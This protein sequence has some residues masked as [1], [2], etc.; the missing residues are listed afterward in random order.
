[1]PDLRR[2][3][4]IQENAIS[5]LLDHNPG[6]I[7]RGLSVE[8]QPHPEQIPVGVPSELLERRPDVQQA[9]AKLIAANARIGVARAQYFPHIAH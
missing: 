8:E 3:V 5:V 7:D 6:A 9:E 2:Q 1:L 4:A